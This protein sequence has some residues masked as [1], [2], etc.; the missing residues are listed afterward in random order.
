MVCSFAKARFSQ[1]LA[2]YKIPAS[3]I[4]IYLNHGSPSIYSHRER[5]LFLIISLSAHSTVVTKLCPFF[6]FNPRWTQ[7][8]RN[9]SAPRI[10]PAPLGQPMPTRYRVLDT[11]NTVIEIKESVW[12][13]RWRCK[14]W[15]WSDKYLGQPTYFRKTHQASCDNE[16]LLAWSNPGLLQQS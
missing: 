7:L 9:F 12:I 16:V 13:I 3:K 5:P 1:I 11:E 6:R 14:R 4:F 15:K 8:I 10:N 2:G